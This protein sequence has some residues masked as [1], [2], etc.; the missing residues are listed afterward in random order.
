MTAMIGLLALTAGQGLMVAILML[1][2]TA[3]I[4]MSVISDLNE[5]DRQESHHKLIREI[6]NKD[7][8]GL[9]VTKHNNQRG[10]IPQEGNSHGKR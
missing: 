3:I 5:K 8:D 9:P 1:A 10:D 6:R 2:F 7:R 4:F